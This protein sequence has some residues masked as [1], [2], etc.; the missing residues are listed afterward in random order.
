MYPLSVEAQRKRVQTNINILPYTK[1]V[2]I[3]KAY[4]FKALELSQLLINKNKR[5]VLN[6]RICLTLFF[7]GCGHCV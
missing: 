7:S 2:F 3:F 5:I 6:T 4:L 1:F